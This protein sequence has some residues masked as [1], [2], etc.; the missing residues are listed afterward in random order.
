MSEDSSFDD[1]GNPQ[2]DS[3]KE[4]EPLLLDE[5]TIP[6]LDSQLA[7]AADVLP[8]SES[9]MRSRKPAKHDRKR[10]RVAVAK[11]TRRDG[12]RACCLR[13]CCG[14]Q[15]AVQSTISCMNI[16]A[17]LVFWGTIVALSAGVVFY[18]YELW[19]NGK[20]P[21]LIAWFSA[22]AFVLLGF[23]ISMWGIFSHLAY[24]NQPHVQVYVVRILWMVPIYSVER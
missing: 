4:H 19:N 21:Q 1:L 16:L 20:D 9:L 23:P 7:A 12:C 3:L 18:S 24:Y 8:K 11:S 6:N 15:L 13:L 10:K 22:G 17:K 2:D 5:H 14:H